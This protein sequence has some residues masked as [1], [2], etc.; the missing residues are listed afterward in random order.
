MPQPKKINL[1]EKFQLFNDYWS[2]KVVADLND[3]QVKLAKFK[4]EFNWHHHDNEDEL[5][6]VIKG[7]LKIQFRDKDITA[8][9]GEMILVPRKV[10]HCPLAED[11]V[12][13]ILIEPNT[14]LNTGNVRTD[15]TVEN[16]QKI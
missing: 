8:K 10:E 1:D 7:E 6:I 12:W 3:S 4:G 14:T 16:L 9:P 13:V 15:K 11:E 5:F 2:P